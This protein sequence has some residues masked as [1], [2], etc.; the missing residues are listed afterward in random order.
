MR[1]LLARANREVLEQFACSSTLLAFDFDGTLAP[2]VHDPDLAAMRPRTLRLLRELAR[3]YPCAVLSGRSRADVLRRV[4]GVRF[5]EV[6]GNHGGEPRR[7]SPRARREVR[8]WLR[9]LRQ[10][11]GGI[12]GVVIEDKGLSLSLHYRR[13]RQKRRARA[14]ILA[15]ASRLGEAR[16]TGGKLVVNV[17]PAGA[18]HKGQALVRT[19]ARLG[20]DTAVY[21]G[22]DE[23][24]ED[25]FALDQPGQLL[26]VRVGRKQGSSAAYYIRR[27]AEID[28][29]LRSLLASRPRAARERGGRVAT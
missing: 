19:R 3:A 6:I 1:Y 11:L 13:A 12:S 24:D 16:V 4:R 18:P 14:R 17:V 22:D 20:C 9:H 10:R 28:R 21:L 29:V 8:R 27:Q 7:A 25:V 15:A 5:A 26:T 2:I 23:T